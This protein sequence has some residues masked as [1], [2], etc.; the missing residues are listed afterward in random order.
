MKGLDFHEAEG[1]IRTELIDRELTAPRPPRQ[2]EQIPRPPLSTR[3]AREQYG[4][5][6]RR[7][8]R[9]SLPPRSSTPLMVPA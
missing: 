8:S 7:E 9:T 1:E 6:P 2:C 3:R 5:R 4:C